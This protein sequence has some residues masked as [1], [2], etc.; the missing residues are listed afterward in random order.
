MLLG[1]VLDLKKLK[2][3]FQKIYDNSWV[4]RLVARCTT[5]Q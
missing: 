2:Q 1:E 5:Q 3:W 4:S